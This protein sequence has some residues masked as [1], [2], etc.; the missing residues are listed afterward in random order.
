MT[1]E[2]RTQVLANAPAWVWEHIVDTA[3]SAMASGYEAGL[4]AGRAAGIEEAR[5]A[6]AWSGAAQVA[7]NVAN[8]RSRTWATDGGP[9]RKGVAR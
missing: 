7:R 5:A 6:A 3:C 2:E 8:D 4:A 9:Q 1:P